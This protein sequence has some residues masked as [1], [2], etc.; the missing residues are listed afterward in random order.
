[1]IRTRKHVMDRIE[2]ACL[3]RSVRRAVNEG[4]IEYLGGFEKLPSC[5]KAF[6][7][8]A[9]SPISEKNFYLA[10]ED[11][12]VWLIQEPSWKYWVGDESDNPLYQG[13]RPQI[14]RVL[15]KNVFVKEGLAP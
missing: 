6:V 12:A 11:K 13:D 5:D 8:R 3:P 14:Y 9:T 2:A 1:M 4:R 10:V 7:A 15:K